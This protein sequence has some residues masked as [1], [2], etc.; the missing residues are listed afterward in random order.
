M[1]VAR[2]FCFLRFCFLLCAFG[3][4]CC[5]CC[6]CRRAGRRV[7]FPKKKIQTPKPKLLCVCAC[8]CRVPRRVAGGNRWWRRGGHGRACKARAPRV[9]FRFPGAK[10]ASRRPCPR[11]P[12][13]RSPAPCSCFVCF[14][15]L[16]LTALSLPSP[17]SGSCKKCCR[18][19]HH[20]VGLLLSS[21]LPA[22]H[23]GHNRRIQKRGQGQGQDTDK[24][25]E[26]THGRGL[27]IVVVGG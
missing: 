10:Q 11:P 6:C 16:K 17:S 8:V 26:K 7:S 18:R 14:P 27:S 24:K 5:C 19:H 20:H 22:T 3:G 2:S 9:S 25:K 1:A 15:F 21:F 23:R 12:P 4:R 13:S